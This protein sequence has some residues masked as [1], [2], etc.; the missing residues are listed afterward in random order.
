MNVSTSGRSRLARLAGAAA[1][2]AALGLAPAGG[3]A[4]AG[5]AAAGSISTV[6]GGVGGPG[7][8]TTVGLRDISGFATAGGQLYV[9]SDTVRAV[10]EQTDA[11]TTPVG[12]GTTPLASWSGGL[13]RQS[14]FDANGVATGPAGSL[15]LCSSAQSAVAVVPAHTGTLYGR[16]MTARHIYRVAGDGF[17]GFAGDGGRAATAELAYPQAVAVDAHSNLI[18]DDWGNGRI[19]VVAATTGTFYQKKMTAGHIYTVAGGGNPVGLGDGGLATAASLSEPSDVTVDTH[20]N[21]IITDTDHQVIRVV[22]ATTGTFYQ[23]KM[24]AGHIYTVA[25]GGTATGDGGLATGAQ[26]NDPWG[27]AVDAAGNLVFAD[28]YSES[29]PVR[30]VAAT[31]GTFYQKKMTAGHLYQIATGALAAVGLDSAGNVVF[32]GSAGNDVKALAVHTGT[33]Y[34]QQ[35]TAGHVYPIAGN[36]TASYSGDGGAATVAQLNAPRATA[37]A[38]GDGVIIADA[39]N[40][41]I[42]MVAGQTGTFYGQAM[43][44]GD[45]YTVAGT[46]P[47][48]GPVKNSTSKN[49]ASKNSAAEN[50][51]VRDGAL[52][53]RTPLDEPRGVTV[54]AHG[55]LVIADTLGEQ[56][57]VVADRTGTFYG[58]QM[59]AGHAYPVAG[60]GIE[61]YSGD[62]GPA[63]AARL[64]YPS[65]VAVDA[66]GNLLVADTANHRVRLV[67]ERSGTFYGQQATAGDIYTIAG[68]GSR[69][70]GGDGGPAAD[71]Q[72]AYPG[73]A[74]PDATGDV[75]IADTSNNRIRMIAGRTGTFYG[76]AMTAGDIYTIAGDGTLGFYGDGGPA[77]AAEL[78]GPLGVSLDAAGNLLI[79]DTG[80]NRIRVIA[81]TTGTFYGQAMTAG[82]VYTVAGSGTGAFSGDG[83]PARRAD[84]DQPAGVS[85]GPGGTLLVADRGNDRI[86]KVTGAPAPAGQGRVR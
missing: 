53:T 60:S 19:R 65:G 15:V 72:L 7:P 28:D 37:D 8:A 43:T 26:L 3:P 81:A 35:M 46:G 24:T 61:G 52:G 40:D 69:G 78:S 29:N 4:S 71:A 20:G 55:N 22:A 36:G 30:V 68:T 12:T 32:G 41:A 21:L 2:A 80:N 85:T 45:V 33:F 18:I 25:G 66:A 11:L 14:S 73:L 76:Q 51:A 63:V 50:S 67:A 77:T 27:V 62:D 23:K 48:D 5:T 39:D 74:V 6:A 79:A 54:D 49:S 16:H 10:S 9:A 13:A 70:F 59:T 42:R 57:L 84:L 56:V 1:V 82:D 86:R 17:P 38:P 34:G 75:F 58:Q 47:A 44:K 31:T 83:G 64:N